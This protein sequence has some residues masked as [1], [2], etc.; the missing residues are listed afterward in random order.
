MDICLDH[1]D[2]EK[3]L[4]CKQNWWTGFENDVKFDQLKFNAD[5]V[6]KLDLDNVKDKNH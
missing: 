3:S 1:Q 5:K 2:K 4:D 6:L